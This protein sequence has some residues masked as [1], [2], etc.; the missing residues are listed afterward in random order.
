[1]SEHVG[2]TPE[3]CDI[4][5]DW[6]DEETTVGVE[7]AFPVIARIVAERERVAAERALREAADAWE[8]DVADPTPRSGAHA[9]GWLRRRA[10]AL[11]A[12]QPADAPEG[13]GD[14]DEAGGGDV[15]RGVRLY[16]E[17]LRRMNPSPR[18]QA[19]LDEIEAEMREGD[20]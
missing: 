6:W 5:R 7:S 14:A 20:R 13:H 18:V 8:T 3:E 16:I 2:L 10:D 4:L 19:A 15:N 1:M 11:S 12:P 17:T 9:D